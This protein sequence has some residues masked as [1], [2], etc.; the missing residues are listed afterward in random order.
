LPPVF[1]LGKV[2]RAI[3]GHHVARAGFGQ[4]AHAG[5]GTGRAGPSDCAFHVVFPWCVRW[6]V[7]PAK[8]CMYVTQAYPSAITASFDNFL[9]VKTLNLLQRNKNPITIAN[10]RAFLHTPVVSS[11]L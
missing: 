2:G 8:W 5:A 3:H 1:R 4:K 10:S 7:V 9:H 6:T 11:T